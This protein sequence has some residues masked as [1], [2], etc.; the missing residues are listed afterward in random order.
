MIR[1]VII[2]LTVFSI[3]T[4]AA[5]ILRC[6]S[7]KPGA[8]EVVGTVYKAGNGKLFV[9]IVSNGK[10]VCTD[11]VNMGTETGTS[12]GKSYTRY[13]FRGMN[14]CWV[15]ATT[16]LIPGNFEIPEYRGKQ[17]GEISYIDSTGHWKTYPSTACEKLTGL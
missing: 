12:G 6:T 4:H 9:S 2:F 17:A 1:L 15:E 10:R 16:I 8:Y 3:S 7:I 13:N 11:S 14:D 5:E